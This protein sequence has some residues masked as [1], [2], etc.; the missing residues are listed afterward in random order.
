[1]ELLAQRPNLL[2]G[3]I[4]RNNELY[5]RC[6]FLVSK[7]RNTIYNNKILEALTIVIHYTYAIHPDLP[8]RNYTVHIINGKLHKENGPA[9]TDDNGSEYWFNNNQLH[10]G[11]IDEQTQ[12][13]AYKKIRIR[14]DYNPEKHT[15]HYKYIIVEKYYIHGQLNRIKSFGREMPTIMSS[16]KTYYHVDG[17][18]HR[19]D[20]PAKDIYGN[21]EWWTKGKLN[22]TDGMGNIIG[23]ARVDGEGNLKWYKNG[24]LHNIYGPAVVLQDGSFEWRYNGLLHRLDG[25]AILY[26]NL[27]D[28]ELAEYWYVDGEKCR[29]YEKG[30][31]MP[32]TVITDNISK[33]VVYLEWGLNGEIHREDGPARVITYSDAK[34]EYWYIDGKNTEKTG[35][36][37]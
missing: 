3:V 15:P 7:I 26:K 14:S 31:H 30:V 23:P 25:P 6:G 19:E 28:N 21:L 18:L 35:L 8:N 27:V 13:P 24:M 11:P 10:R 1:M 32:W 33:K 2:F 36:L 22:H 5:Y 20:G 17:I 4:I 37:R 12:L 29:I 9:A 16:G 34:I